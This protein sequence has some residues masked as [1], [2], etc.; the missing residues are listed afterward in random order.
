MLDLPPSEAYFRSV[1]AAAGVTPSIA[2][3]TISV[4]SV[5]ALVAVGAGYS[6]LL[7]RSSVPVS[8]G[9]VSFA[10]CE[11]EEDI[12][13]VAVQL[14]MPASARLTRRAQ[15]FVNFCQG[16]FHALGDKPPGTS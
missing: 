7:Q 10:V 13:S 3:R 4:E 5:R 12:R 8:Y 11:I 16:H 6:A 1:F 9:G 15:A 2:Q 14:T